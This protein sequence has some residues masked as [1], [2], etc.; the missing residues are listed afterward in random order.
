MLGRC[1]SVTTAVSIYSTRVALSIARVRTAAGGGRRAAARAL[2]RVIRADKRAPRGSAAA[3]AEAATLPTVDGASPL[4][5]EGSAPEVPDVHLPES[6]DF[7]RCSENPR[8]QYHRKND[9]DYDILCLQLHRTC[10]SAGAPAE[11]TLVG[12]IS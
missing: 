6:V 3:L 1:W 11:E 2:T 10:R 7:R 5:A 12:V 4:R 9:K 8:L